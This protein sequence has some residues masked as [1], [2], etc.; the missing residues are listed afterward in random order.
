LR[1]PKPKEIRQP[2][3]RQTNTDTEGLGAARA[4]SQLDL[5]GWRETRA[6]LTMSKRK[7]NN[8]ILAKSSSRR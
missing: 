2:K 6:G 7:F 8:I 4:A 3:G 1:W 5:P